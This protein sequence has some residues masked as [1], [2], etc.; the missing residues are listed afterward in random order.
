MCPA[1]QS[2]KACAA[3]ATA[4]SSSAA[5]THNFVRGTILAGSLRCLLLSSFLARSCAAETQT[6]SGDSQHCL[7]PCDCQNNFAAYPQQ[8][9]DLFASNA[10]TPF[11]AFNDFVEKQG[12]YNRTSTSTTGKPWDFMGACNG[13][14][15]ECATGW[16]QARGFG[17]WS[18]GFSYS[19]GQCYVWHGGIASSSELVTLVAD[20]LDLLADWGGGSPAAAHALLERL[21]VC[22]RA[23]EAELE[24]EGAPKEE[25]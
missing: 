2:Q 10:P 3:E 20:Q 24:A 9:R 21:H 17:L 18:P 8:Y 7:G 4:R 22:S 13:T 19:A 11:L 23:W 1:R 25:L 15:T 5:R 12:C 6:G 14:A 16:C